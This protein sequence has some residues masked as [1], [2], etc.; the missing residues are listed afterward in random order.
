MRCTENSEDPTIVLFWFCGL[1][2]LTLD[3]WGRLPLLAIAL[4][5]M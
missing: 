1:F 4:S 3:I 5:F 2:A